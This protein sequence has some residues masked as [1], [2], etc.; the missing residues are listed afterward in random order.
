MKGCRHYA[1]DRVAGVAFLESAL[2]AMTWQE[3][4]PQARERT[5]MIRTSGVGRQFVLEHNLF[6]HTA[7]RSTSLLTQTAR[8][9]D[10]SRLGPAC[11]TK[12]LL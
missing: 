12:V 7:G 5:E 11:R 10:R 8:A 3:V 6:V 2:R 1:D 9:S 4:S